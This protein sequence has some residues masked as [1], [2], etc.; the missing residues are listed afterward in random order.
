[1]YNLMLH[2]KVYSVQIKQQTPI[3]KCTISSSHSGSLTLLDRLHVLHSSRYT[4]RLIGYP[5]IK[6]Y[7]F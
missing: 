6:S 2:L 1:M 5:E 7:A 4:P 3:Q